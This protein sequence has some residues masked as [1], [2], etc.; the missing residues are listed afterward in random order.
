MPKPILETWKGELAVTAFN[1]VNFAIDQ[2]GPD[3]GIKLQ[4][5]KNS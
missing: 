5:N 2:A 4:G 3:N 1:I